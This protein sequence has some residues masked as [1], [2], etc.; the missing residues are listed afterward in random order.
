MEMLDAMLLYSL[1]SW[2]VQRFRFHTEDFVFA[3]YEDFD[4][5]QLVN[6]LTQRILMNS[7]QY[8]TIT[9]AVCCLS[10]DF[11]TLLLLIKHSS[12]SVICELACSVDYNNV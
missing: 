5:T 7:K 1:Y 8:T 3:K 2:I 12:V 11:Y 4:S 10:I 6:W 9:Y